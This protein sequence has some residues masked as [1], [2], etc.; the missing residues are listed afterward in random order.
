MR[1]G[2]KTRMRGAES[3]P[4]H[5]LLARGPLGHVDMACGCGRVLRVHIGPVSLRF[6]RD[7]LA[8]LHRTLGE[9]L[10]TLARER[11]DTELALDLTN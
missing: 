8:A 7:G 2:R 5:R 1:F 4:G 3:E 9:A 10:E 11:R 6:D